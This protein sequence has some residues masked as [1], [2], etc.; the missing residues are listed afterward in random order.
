MRPFTR[1]T[2][3]QCGC[4]YQGALTSSGH[5]RSKPWNRALADGTADGPGRV[6]AAGADGLMIEV[7][8]HPE[9]ALS[10]GDS[11][12]TP[13]NFRELMDEV[14]RIAAVRRA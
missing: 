7:H 10:D 2:L 14:H 4:G 6:I 1:N 12:L 8:P 11:S 5:R 13:E 3:I 9:M